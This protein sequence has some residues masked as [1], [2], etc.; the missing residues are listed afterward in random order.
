[1]PASHFARSERTGLCNLLSELGPEAPT[2]CEGWLTKDLAAHLFVRERRP[3]AMPGLVLGGPPARLTEIAMQ[4]ALKTYGYAGL[5]ARVRSGPP[6]I[7]RPLDEL[8]NLMEYFVHTEDVRRAA[9][10]WEPRDNA[11]LD[12][13]LWASLRRSARMFSRRIRGAGLELEAPDGERER[14]VV[15][16]SDPR[17]VLSGGPQ[18]IV[19][20]L[21]GRGRVAQASLGGPEAAQAAVRKAGFKV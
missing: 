2:L 8:V 17:A 12:T 5:V 14:I 18:E 16:T 13:A 4:A 21:F 15:R 20:Y 1:M 7:G 6:A 9:P 3:L 19:L 11:A 10:S